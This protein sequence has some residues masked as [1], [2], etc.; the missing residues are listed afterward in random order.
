MIERDC[1][2]HE[3]NQP[4]L[5]SLKILQVVFRNRGEVEDDRGGV[6]KREGD[7]CLP[8]SG[9]RQCLRQYKQQRLRRD[10]GR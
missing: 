3:S 4:A 9:G 5:T 6:E 1:C 7:E 8:A 10:Q 2:F